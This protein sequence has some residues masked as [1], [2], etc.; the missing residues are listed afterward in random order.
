MTRWMSAAL[1]TLGVGVAPVAMADSAPTI[2]SES[3]EAEAASAVAGYEKGFFIRSADGD[4]GITFQGLLQARYT[5]ENLDQ[6]GDNADVSNFSLPRARLSFGGNLFGKNLT[7]K[8]QAD[9]GKGGAALKDFYAEYAIV[10]RWLHVRAGQWKRPFSRQLMTSGSKFQLVDREITN[11]AFGAGRDLGVSVGND[12]EESPTLEWV[13]GVFNGTGEKGN[14]SGA[15]SVDPATDKGKITSGRFNNVPTVFNPTLVARIG[16][17]HGGIKGYSESD[18]EGGPF[19]I[20][21]GV[22]GL[23]E[24]DADEDDQSSIRGEIDAIMKVEGFAFSAA[25][26]VASRQNGSTFADRSIQA[27]GMHAQAGYVI[28]GLV[29]PILR[30][31]YVSEE[32]DNNDVKA[33]TGGVAVYV[34][35]TTF[36]WVTD[37]TGTLSQDAASDRTDVRVQSQLQLTL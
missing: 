22:S 28:A 25:G 18:L 30:F 31:G 26:F 37:C 16:F 33:I 11:E 36:K 10:P 14:L 20:G 15:V 21:I 4:F 27:G 9:F 8:F 35:G 19:R 12:Y 29:E 7:Y 17:N 5:Y 6:P 24:M 23:V 34:Y 13:V 2:G 32:G 3:G 1:I